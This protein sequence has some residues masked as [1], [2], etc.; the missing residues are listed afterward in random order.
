MKTIRLAVFMIGSLIALNAAAQTKPR[1]EQADR[2]EKLMNS[3]P[4]ERANRQ[5]QQMKKDL[6][7]TPEQEKE[8]AV[9][10][11][12]YARQMQPVIEQAQRDRAT[13]KQM[14]QMNSAKEKDL[15]KV[16]NDKQFSEYE[17]RKDERRERM[18]ERRG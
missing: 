16:L 9:I 10:N 7:L 2:R 4:E 11:L 15:R 1:P 14:R 12:N 3:T 5:T 6:A 13:M 17:S 8:V 18:K